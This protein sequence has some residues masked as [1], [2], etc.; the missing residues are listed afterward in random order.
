MND[1]VIAVDV[2]TQTLHVFAS[3][4]G[5]II[6]KRAPLDDIQF[7]PGPGNL[8][9]LGITG[10]SRGDRGLV[11]PTVASHPV[12]GDSGLVVLSSDDLR[13]TYRHAEMALSTLPPADAADQSPPD[14]VTRL[15]ASV[16]SAGTI[17]LSWE[18]A[19]DGDRWWP[20]ADG[21]PASAYVVLRNGTEIGTVTGTSFID[22]SARVGAEPGGPLSSTYEVHAV[23]VS[24][25]RSEPVSLVLALPAEAGSR[26]PTVAGIGLLLL[27]AVTG[28]VALYRRRFGRS[29]GTATSF[30]PAVDERVPDDPALISPR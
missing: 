25:N 24:G 14:P 21:V 12:D 27:A 6:E 5:N 20:A 29:T 23:D 18:A 19:T 4:N 11:D 15:Q 10:G 26:L 9:V 22:E 30:P 13:F 17:S 7:A 16:L 1:P 8:F 28:A 2:S 3:L